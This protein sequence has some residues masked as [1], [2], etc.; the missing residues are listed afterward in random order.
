M[1]VLEKADYLFVNKEEAEEILYGEELSLK[2]NE[3]QIKKLLYGLRG[4]GAKNIVITDGDN[5]SYVESEK[6]ETYH[7]GI[8]KVEVAEKTGAGDAYSAGFLA[9]IIHGLEIPEA[10][11]WGTINSASVIGKIGAEE[12]LLT[13]QELEEKLITN[14]SL[15]A[16][17]I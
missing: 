12:G 2:A 11:K 17:K 5:G 15:K 8:I 14:E 3:D 10:M 13:K 1:D 4:L 6:N 9:A 7:L 16:E